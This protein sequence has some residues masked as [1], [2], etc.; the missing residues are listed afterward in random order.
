MNKNEPAVSILISEV[1]L[2]LFPTIFNVRRDTLNK[3]WYQLFFTGGDNKLS[4]DNSIEA[5]SNFLLFHSSS[6][7]QVW[8]I[9]VF[10]LCLSHP[11]LTTI[12]SGRPY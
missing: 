8:R 1:S 4:E 12:Q 5:R 10:A 11:N 7:N 3:K 6:E 2:P 9:F